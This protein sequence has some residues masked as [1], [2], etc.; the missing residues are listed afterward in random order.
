MR[1]AEVGF[2]LY[3]DA[4]EMER[5][6]EKREEGCGNIS[7]C[8]TGSSGPIDVSAACTPARSAS[9]QHRW[10]AR[11]VLQQEKIQL[12]GSRCP[13]S[14]TLL[15]QTVT[16]SKSFLT[17]EAT[18]GLGFIKSNIKRKQKEMKFFFLVFFSLSKELLQNF[19]CKVLVAPR[20]CF[21]SGPAAV[22]FH[23]LTIAD[24]TEHSAHL[25]LHNGDC[26]SRHCNY[27]YKAS[28]PPLLLDSCPVF[29][30]VY[31]WDSLGRLG[32]D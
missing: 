28:L 14:Y 32:R 20:I 10:A 22:R 9:Y 25:L 13:S 4:K 17:S 29:V 24:H 12:Q 31:D 19:H 6:A 8:C 18:S 2:A 15:S 27:I 30:P 3:A 16:F 11:S 23:C 5:A 21:H 1:T 26:L 7:S